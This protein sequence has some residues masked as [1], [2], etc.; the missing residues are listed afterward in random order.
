MTLIFAVDF[1]PQISLYGRVPTML[2]A[3]VGIK[4]LQSC[5][6]FCDSTD[7]GPPGSSV[8]E[9]LQA[10]IL[11]WVSKPSS[12][13]SSQLG[14]LPNSGI[15]FPRLLHCRWILYYWATE[16]ANYNVYFLMK[17][18]NIWNWIWTFNFGWRS[19]N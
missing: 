7:C 13:G 8:H 6:T 19:L 18:Q 10:R 14:D 3:C 4:S 12:R 2:Y 11:E 15:E 1:S 9:I 5:L 16:E 17:K